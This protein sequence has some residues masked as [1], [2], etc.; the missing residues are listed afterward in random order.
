MSGVIVVPWF[1]RS[2]VNITAKWRTQGWRCGLKRPF[3]SFMIKSSNF[4]GSEGLLNISMLI[5]CGVEEDEEESEDDKEDGDKD[6]KESEEDKEEDEED[7]ED[8]DDDERDEEEEEED[9][10]DDDE[11]EEED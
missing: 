5:F 9:D 11:E 8:A 3:A 7:K 1:S 2:V 4:I 6:D 10:D